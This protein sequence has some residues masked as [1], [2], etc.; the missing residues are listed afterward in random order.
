[1]TNWYS[2]PQMILFPKIFLEKHI[3]CITFL[4]RCLEYFHCSALVL[5]KFF[6]QPL[7]WLLHENCLKIQ[8]NLPSGSRGS[9]CRVCSAQWHGPAE[10][11]SPC[12]RRTSG[13]IFFWVG[14]IEKCTVQ[15]TVWSQKHSPP[16]PFVF[17]F[18]GIWSTPEP[19][20]AVLGTNVPWILGS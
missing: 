15:C 3:F 9:W 7:T 13:I 16:P 4:H 2:G 11:P 18:G 17:I 10:Y 20:P 6:Y 1:M 8:L 12:R 5:L 14:A 19:L